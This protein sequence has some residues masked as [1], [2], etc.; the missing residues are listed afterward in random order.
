MIKLSFRKEEEEDSQ[1]LNRIFVQSI[2]QIFSV[3]F[4]QSWLASKALVV[5]IELNTSTRWDFFLFLS[6][7]FILHFFLRIVDVRRAKDA[8]CLRQKRD[9]QNV[10]FSLS[11]SLSFSMSRKRQTFPS[12]TTTS[13]TTTNMTF[14]SRLFPNHYQSIDH[15]HSSQI[16]FFSF[17]FFS[18]F[19]YNVLW[20][21]DYRRL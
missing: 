11:L 9:T 6:R 15:P 3:Y 20:I 21:I 13:T 10:I 7:M 4:T 18:S 17:S 5:V 19:S 1:M 14:Y 16:F 2:R 8:L 12:W